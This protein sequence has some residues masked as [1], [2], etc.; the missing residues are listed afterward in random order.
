MGGGNSSRL[1]PMGGGTFPK[2]LNDDTL[3][4]RPAPLP[5]LFCQAIKEIALRTVL[6][7]ESGASIFLIL[8]TKKL[9]FSSFESG[10]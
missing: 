5:P 3:V 1:S 2:F 4:G 9:I 6:S 8:K 10:V 7:L